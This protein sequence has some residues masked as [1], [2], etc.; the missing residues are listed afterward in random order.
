MVFPTTAL[1]LTG[2][3][4]QP[5]F[6]GFQPIG[7]TDMV[8]VFN[9]NFSYNLP[10][11]EVPGPNGGYPL[12]LSY[13]AGIGME[14]EA[15][16]VGL[17]WNLN[18]GSIT[19]NLRGVPDDFNGDKIT[20]SYYIK[21]N[22]NVGLTVGSPNFELFNFDASKGSLSLNGTL[23]YN[24]YK[25]AGVKLGLDA[26]ASLGS[27]LGG[28]L[29]INFDNRSGLD[30]NPS[31]S[32][33]HKFD[34]I[35][36]S[37]GVG[38]GASF[39]STQG[40]RD[41]S[42]Q[43]I[44]ESDSKPLRGK[45]GKDFNGFGGPAGMSFATKVAVPKTDVPLK[46]MNVGVALRPGFA[47]LG[48]AAK[49]KLGANFADTWVS[50][51]GKSKAFKSYGYMY[52]HNRNSDKDLIDFNRE[53]DY[54]ITKDAPYLALPNFSYDIYNVRAQGQSAM[55]R[56]RRS[57]FGVLSDPHIE[58]T[59]GGGEVTVEAAGG[60][61]FKVGGDINVVFGKSWSGSMKEDGD[62]RSHFD[63]KSEIPASDNTDQ[64][65]K[66]EPY[67]FKNSGEKTAEEVDTWNKIRDEQQVAVRMKMGFS[68][69]SFKPRISNYFE[70]ETDPETD[71]ENARDPIKGYRQ[72]RERRET[73]MVVRTIGDL[74]GS[75]ATTQG[76][77]IVPTGSYPRNSTPT[78]YGYAN[79]IDSQVGKMECI[80]PN[81]YT[82]HYDI[83][84]YNTYQK[85]AVFAIDGRN[86]G[87]TIPY[88]QTTYSSSDVSHNNGNG[89]D[90]F[91][92][93]TELP[94]YAHSYLLTQ[95]TSPDYVDLTG[96]GPTNDDFGY[97]V[98][99]YYNQHAASG[100]EYE[101]R[102]PYTKANYIP[103]FYS[104]TED[105]KA[106]YVYGKKE[107]YYLNAIETKTHIAEFTLS[108]R[109][110][111]KGAPG[112]HG[113][114]TAKTL[115]KLDRITLYS[116]LDPNYISGTPTPVKQIHFVYNYS[117]CDGI[118]NNSSGNGKLTLEQVYFTYGKNDKGSLSPYRFEY[119]ETGRESDQNPDYKLSA[120]DRWGNYK[121]F[122][123]SP[124]HYANHVD[125]PY[126]NQ[127]EDYDGD[128]DAD[129]TD[130]QK[131]SDHASAWNL[132]KIILPSGGEIAVAYESDDYAYVQDKKAMNMMK[133]VGAGTATGNSLS[134]S[135]PKIYFKPN[136]VTTAA[137]FSASAI[138]KYYQSLVGKDV[139][140]KMYVDLKY[141]PFTTIMKKDYVTGYAK[142]SAGGYD[143]STGTGWGSLNNVKK[144]NNTSNTV[145]PV[146]KA[147]WQYL[148]MSR[149]ELFNDPGSVSGSP[150]NVFGTVWSF[151][152]SIMQL[153][154]GFYNYCD[155]NSYA[156]NITLSSS[157]ESFI[158]LEDSNGI[159]YGGGHRVK[160]ITLNDSWGSMT[161]GS[162][163][164]FSYGQEYEY[165]LAD[166]TSSGV[167]AY[168][169]LIGG[170]ENPHRMPFRY[171]SDDL[172]YQKE[173][174][175]V[176][177]PIGESF[178]P[179]ADVGYSRVV[180]K[181]ITR[182]EELTA[183]GDHKNPGSAAATMVHEFYTAKDFPVIEK[184]T[185]IQNDDRYNLM[186]PVPF[187]GVSRFNNNGFS[188]GYAI[189]LNDMHGQK[190]RYATFKYG[191]DYNDNSQAVYMEEYYYNTAQPY[192][193]NRRNELKSTVPVLYGEKIL[194]EADMGKSMDF[195]MD[196]RSNYSYTQ[197]IGAQIDVHGLNLIF[198]FLPWF[199]AIPVLNFDEQ[200]FSSVVANKVIFKSAILKTV[201]TYTEG[202]LT[203]KENLYF[204]SETGN[205]LVSRIS[206]EFKDDIY[207]MDIP[208]HWY[209]KNF[210]G[211][212]RNVG[213]S[214]AASEYTVS[215]NEIT[216]TDVAD[217]RDYFALG[218]QLKIGSSNQYWVEEVKPG[219]IKVKNH[220]NSFVTPSADISIYSSGNKN[221]LQASLGTIVSKSDP[222]TSRV[223]PV[224]TKYNS[225]TTLDQHPMGS[226]NGSATATDCDNYQWSVEI[227]NAPFPSG[228]TCVQNS[229]IGVLYA[230]ASRFKSG[231]TDHCDFKIRILNV[232]YLQ[233][234]PLGSNDLK[235][236][237]FNRSGDNLVIS[238]KNS[239][240]TYYA[241]IDYCSTATTKLG[242]G[243]MDNVI[244]ANIIAGGETDHTSNYS[245][246][247]DF[248]GNL[249]TTQ[250][251]NPQASNANA[252]KMGTKG[253]WR[254]DKSY[255]Y[256]TDRSAN[257][258]GGNVLLKQDGVISDFNFFDHA[259]GQNIGSD[260]VKTEQ[261]SKIDP[262]GNQL[263]SYD[264]LGIYSA[265]IYGY[266][267]SMLTASAS[268]SKYGEIAFESF[269]EHPATTYVA[270]GIG[271]VKL[272]TS[273]SMSV[274]S[275]KSHTGNRSLSF[276]G[277]VNYKPSAVSTMSLLPSK[278][279]T[280]KVWL[281][282]GGSVQAVISGGSTTSSTIEAK[283]IDGWDL[284]KLTFSAPASLSSLTLRFNSI[285]GGTS[286]MDDLR[287]Y[288]SD[289]MLITY[290]Y[291]RESFKVRAIIDQL[292]F[293]ETYAYDEENNLV[294]INRETEQGVLTI[295]E[296]RKHIQQ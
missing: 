129:A 148:R 44:E 49:L 186:I 99:F 104:N 56:P 43:Y 190:K 84:V 108:N 261:F 103:G 109:Q 25:G 9:G 153:I 222:V 80:N 290:V 159:K 72:T 102:E 79:G 214:F 96:D 251:A 18:V 112:E 223:M 76:K 131:R 226:W 123:T 75:S 105:D 165:R 91:Y 78:K 28:R 22:W 36:R 170:E 121:N 10:L 193:P 216:F 66:Y 11:L 245:E 293:A 90:E 47:G 256:K 29:T 39:H 48:F 277:T 241:L 6:A 30:V 61:D 70:H 207:T 184:H 52:A 154:T 229:E 147:A 106:S 142:I 231:V 40:F 177:S 59:N 283:N 12:N 188:Q 235:N 2:G 143:A 232:K 233:S 31:L 195:Y 115:K 130:Y 155:I 97:W 282:N 17:G 246:L 152:K 145:N 175:Y 8:N 69:G 116:K 240:R 150:L 276:T 255:T 212:Y 119:E 209:D 213:T 273:G 5:E 163:S 162:E 27:V 182:A 67:Y 35:G 82:Y 194:G 73:N 264:A 292:N 100:S 86:G 295:R 60:T 168:E 144:H 217:H 32:L 198:F 122:G 167:A 267:N 278:Q 172:V 187:V 85:E 13:D 21:P 135:S 211:A 202:K 160:R 83:P 221:N 95:I 204:D 158:R 286:Y 234:H 285:S 132:R 243:C 19:R 294:R 208:G 254:P 287:L 45:N 62:F 41:L 205:P 257:G 94:K 74:G 113:T 224:F 101:W 275:T 51:E 53:K 197:S 126:T 127:N 183:G 253:V 111:G 237:Y 120:V 24:S 133:V 3:P 156:R 37:F 88:S 180:V 134:D 15:S 118:Y 227:S 55:F 23:Y 68:G 288:P 280:L 140:F 20:K 137:G 4:S 239:N 54:A 266:G 38:I 57:D 249:I 157:Y 141:A 206:N 14:Q 71:Y 274:V 161:G 230:K 289:G 164:D 210:K 124:E 46:G 110:D 192:S 228:L 215:S 296:S 1:A 107:I 284:H 7:V 128:G 238:V 200:T 201:K 225:N 171:N 258:S 178:Y 81:G 279:Y 146:T 281:Q 236:L 77:H 169:P 34:G 247:V 252:Y 42:Y 151:L 93:A 260:W 265:N 16:W 189:H 117:L 269:E 87:T 244:A 181:N 174:L 220:L 63:F 58:S 263:E 242:P 50:S 166:G 191:T 185:Q 89:Q 138:T 33:Q 139:F 259:Y 149:P 65:Q 176:E 203:E 92:S 125:N 199:T 98:K 173:E 219:Y 218:D 271:H 64:Y 262:Y 250:Y 268:N 272:T 196:M 291:D 179:G 26:G 136:E 114:G 248:N 270:N